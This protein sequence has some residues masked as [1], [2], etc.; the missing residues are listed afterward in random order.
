[1]EQQ[2]L[3]ASEVLLFWGH[4]HQFGCQHHRG[5][6]YWASAQPIDVCHVHPRAVVLRPLPVAAVS[7][8]VLIPN[9]EVLGCDEVQK[10]GSTYNRIV[11]QLYRSFEFGQRAR[12]VFFMRS[13]A[14]DDALYWGH[15]SCLSN[16]DGLIQL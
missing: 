7:R 6:R 15:V 1:M 5:F 12:S 2:K 14:E 4:A 9:R 16:R 11:D 10:L 3:L 8:Y 13:K